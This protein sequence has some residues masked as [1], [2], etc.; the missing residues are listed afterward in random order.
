M[1]IVDIQTRRV[2]QSIDLWFA[3]H[4]APAGARDF[5]FPVT[6]IYTDEGIEGYTMD[7]GPLGQGRPSAYAVH[8][9]YYHDLVGKNPLH[10]EAIWQAMRMKQRHLYNFRETI[11]SNLDVALWD[12]KGKAAGMSICT[13][14]GKSVTASPL[15]PPV[16]RKPSARLRT[17]YMKSR[18]RKQKAS[19]VRNSSSWAA[20]KR[21]FP[22]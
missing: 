2:K 6:T 17:P 21:T 12:I 15:T 10:T 1:K 8:D 18:A 5:E 16:R 20:P 14:L 4:P 22:R 13:L 9:I 19:S 3:P 11:W 7:Y